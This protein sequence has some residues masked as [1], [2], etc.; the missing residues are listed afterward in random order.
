MPTQT[1]S[2]AAAQLHQLQ[3][4]RN[5]TSRL[6]DGIPA[7]KVC[8]QPG[9]CVNHAMWITGHLACVDDYFMK[10]FGGGK[11]ALPEKWHAIFG[12]KSKPTADA[13]QYPAYAEVRKAFDERRAAFL[14]WVGGLSSAQLEGPVSEGWRKYARNVGDVAHFAAWHEGYHSGQIA[15]LRRGFGLGPAFG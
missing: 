4:A 3:F 1:V 10:E 12:M 14:K 2:P 15:A 11:L 9:T 6:L 8:A 7:D 5:A 13:K